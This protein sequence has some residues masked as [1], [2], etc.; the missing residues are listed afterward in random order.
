MEHTGRLVLGAILTL[1]LAG[2]AAAA[3]GRKSGP[4]DTYVLNRSDSSTVS[5]TLDAL[6]SLRARY[7]GD[8]LWF[9]RGDK[10]YVIR[11]PR[12]L[13]RAEAFFEPLRDL[14][15]EQDSLARREQALDREE[16]ANDAGEESLDAAQEEETRPTAELAERRRILHARQRDVS[17]RQ[18]ELSQVERALDRRE[19]ALEEAAERELWKFLDRAVEGGTAS[20]ADESR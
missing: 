20:P 2:A 12:L 5:G 16:Q 8:F 4:R 15:P 17:Q 13:A 10:T 7:S 18:R 9:R 6:G 11:D 14:R 19:N 1:S 3:P